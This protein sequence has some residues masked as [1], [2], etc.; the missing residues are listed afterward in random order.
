MKNESQFLRYIFQNWLLINLVSPSITMLYSVIFGDGIE[1]PDSGLKF[2]E[3]YV[4]IFMVTSLYSISGICLFGLI[5]NAIIKH[6]P[7]D[8]IVKWLLVFIMFFII[9][10]SM[11]FFLPKIPFV[12]DFI[13]IVLQFT[14]SYFLVSIF[15]ITKIP[16]R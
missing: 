10:L 15:T 16:F 14:I 11:Y 7:N 9:F 1:L 5:A 12:D 13:K 3:I 8:K 4:L 2:F 6:E